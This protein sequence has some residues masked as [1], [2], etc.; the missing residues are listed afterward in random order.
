MTLT[1]WVHDTKDHNANV[2]S[3]V[4]RMKESVQKRNGQQPEDALKAMA[5]QVC[6][7]SDFQ[8]QIEFIHLNNKTSKKIYLSNHVRWKRVNP[9][10]RPNGWPSKRRSVSVNK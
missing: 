3:L 1:Q 7:I 5:I 8:Y 2:S 6:V 9:N 10:G 4:D